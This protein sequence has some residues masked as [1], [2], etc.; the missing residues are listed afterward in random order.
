MPTVALLTLMYEVPNT[1][2]S[3]ILTKRLTSLNNKL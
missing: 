1:F 3:N 2:F